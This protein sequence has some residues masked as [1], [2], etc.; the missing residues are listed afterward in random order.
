MSADEYAAL[1][2]G[3]FLGERLIAEGVSLIV[4]EEAPVTLA[5]PGGVP[6]V[7]AATQ[8]AG[9]MNAPPSAD[10]VVTTDELDALVNTVDRN[11]VAATSLAVLLR[12]TLPTPVEFGLAAESAVYST[13]QAGAEFASWRGAHAPRLIE[14]PDPTVRV[15]RRDDVLTI[16]LDRPHRHNA[17]SRQLRD[18]LCRGL[19]LALVDDSIASVQLTGRGPSFC[20]GGDL[21]EF[22]ARSDPAAGHRIRLAQSPARLIH[23]LRDRLTAHVHGATLGGGIEMAAFAARVVADPQTRFGLPEVRLGLIPGAGGT[24]SLPRRIGR[25]RTMTLALVHETI[26]APTALDWGLVDEL[27]EQLPSG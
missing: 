21:T 8:S 19:E 24:V 16:A 15:E 27:A 22:G 14:E 4:V 7:V 25:Q 18:E 1:V 2:R 9:G 10:L 5:D 23:R 17:I 26:D 13:L 11:P 20:S 3:P 12:S 6:V